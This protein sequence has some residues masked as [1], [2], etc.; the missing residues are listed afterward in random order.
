M[1]VVVH[2]KENIYS[3]LFYSDDLIIFA[4]G[5]EWGISSMESET[6]L[7]QGAYICKYTDLWIKSARCSV[8]YFSVYFDFDHGMESISSMKHDSIFCHH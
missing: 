2:K 4:Q 6:S 5:S 1:H 8:E 7:W 3:M